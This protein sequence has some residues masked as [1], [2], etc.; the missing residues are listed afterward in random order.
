M[1]CQISR[2]TF[3]PTLL[4]LTLVFYYYYL[5]SDNSSPTISSLG[6]RMYNSMVSIQSSGGRG[7][8]KLHMDM[9]DMFNVMTYASSAP[10]G[11]PGGAEWHVYRAE[12]VDKLRQFLRKRFQGSFQ[13]DPIHSQQFYLDG[14]MRKE[15]YE[16]YGVKSH[17]LFQKPGDAILIPTGCVHQVSS[18][19]SQRILLTNG[20]FDRCLMCLTVSKLEWTLSALKMLSDARNSFVSYGNKI[21]RWSGGKTCCSSGQ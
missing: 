9:V 20:T 3:R 11:G 15:L 1:A 8:T 14:E 4:L 5:L 13:Q 6:P 18:A 21:S 7:A 12:D 10:D 2:R 19:T 16:T 17:R